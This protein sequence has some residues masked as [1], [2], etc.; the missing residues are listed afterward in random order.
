[1]A[2]GSGKTL[3]MYAHILR[4]RRLL[5]RHGRARDLNRI[6]LLTPNEGLSRQHLR[7]FEAAGIEAEIFS[8]ENRGLFTGQAVEILEITKLRDEMGDRTVAVEAFEG[9][10]LVLIDEGHRGAAA[11]EDGAWMRFRNAL[12]E[13][14]FS[15]STA[16]QGGAG[17]E[18]PDVDAQLV[19]DHARFRLGPAFHLQP[20]SDFR[21][22]DRRHRRAGPQCVDHHVR[23]GFF[24]YQDKRGGRIQNDHGRLNPSRLRLGELR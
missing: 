11:G 12:C 22:V 5:M 14:G 9:N 4:Y 10:N 16:Q 19:E 13:K 6:L 3:L 21:H 1:M 23:A 18:R 17:I 8:K 7:E 15:L 24:Q 2:T 20:G